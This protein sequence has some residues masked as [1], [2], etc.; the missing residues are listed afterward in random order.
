MPNGQREVRA[1][2]KQRQ[3]DSLEL[4]CLLKRWKVFQKLPS[5]NKALAHRHFFMT[6]NGASD[7][8]AVS[9][10]YIRSVRPA[11]YQFLRV[12]SKPNQPRP[13][14]LRTR[15]KWERRMTDRILFG[16][17]SRYYRLAP[18]QEMWDHRGLLREGEYDYDHSS[19]RLHSTHLHPSQ[20]WR[21]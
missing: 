4:R 18:G 20:S 3:D 21:I 9:L 11:V 7:R 13:L 2:R 19:P 6:R 17:L 12:V 1:G 14:S 8:I 10:L 5:C 16:R 15:E